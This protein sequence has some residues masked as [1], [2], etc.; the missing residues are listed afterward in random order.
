MWK[1]EKTYTLLVGMSISA[2]CGEQYRY[3]LEKSQQSHLWVNSQRHEHIVSK[4]YCTTILTAALFTIARIW[5]YPR[6]LS[7]EKQIKKM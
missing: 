7:A 3:S 2:D 1:K 4:R 6:Y 5:N